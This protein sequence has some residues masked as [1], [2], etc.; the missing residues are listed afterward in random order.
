MT[1]GHGTTGTA[2][3]YKPW[4]S[5]YN[6]VLARNE[7]DGLLMIA[8]LC[9]GTIDAFGMYARALNG[10]VTAGLFSVVGEYPLVGRF[11]FRRYALTD[12][13]RD[14]AYALACAWEMGILA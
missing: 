12:K 6:V 10:L 14:R 4:P 13:S 11:T 3:P 9:G 1:Q 8:A 2:E 7:N 5:G